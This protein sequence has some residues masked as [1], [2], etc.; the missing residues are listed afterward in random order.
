M[1]DTGISKYLY[2]SNDYTAPKQAVKS[3]QYT[4]LPPLR[5]LF[6]NSV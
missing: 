4:T 1:I 6:G 3:Y 5:M 2:I